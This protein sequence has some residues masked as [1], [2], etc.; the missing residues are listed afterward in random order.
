MEQEQGSMKYF[1]YGSNMDK[2]DLDDWCEDRGHPTVEYLN[3]PTLA[4]LEG[5]GDVQSIVGG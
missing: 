5:Y 4:K 3:I 1:A 2:P